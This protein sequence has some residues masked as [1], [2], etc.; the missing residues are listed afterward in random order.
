MDKDFSNI[1]LYPPGDHHG[2]IIVKLYWIKVSEATKI[3]LDA[4]KDINPEDISTNLSRRPMFW[5]KKSIT[6]VI[7][8]NKITVSPVKSVPDKQK[9]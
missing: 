4:M 8:H 9:L 5:L 1:L 2:I 7:G 3:F 6:R